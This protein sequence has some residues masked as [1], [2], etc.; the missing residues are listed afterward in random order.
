[1]RFAEGS[2]EGHTEDPDSSPNA[3]TALSKK[4]ASGK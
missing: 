1:V 3:K 4:Q 2:D